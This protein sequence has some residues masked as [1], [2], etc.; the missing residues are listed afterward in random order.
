MSSGVFEH[1][2]VIMKDKAPFFS[3]IVPTY[4]RPR[5][6]DSCLNALTRLDYPRDRFEVIVIDDASEIRLDPIVSPYRKKIDVALITQP[7]SGP[8]MARNR[9]AARAK[10]Q[11]LAFTDDDCEPSPDWIKALSAR[12]GGM[13]EQI[14]GGRTLN[15]LAGNAY[16][17]VTQ[18]VTDYVIHHSSF[19]LSQKRFF[20]SNNLAIP[21]DCFHRV[22]GFNTDFPFGAGEDRELS[23]RLIDHQLPLVYAPEVI[24]YHSHRFTLSTFL[25][26]HFDYGRG[27]FQFHQICARRRNQRIM[28]ESKRFYLNLL[29][30]PLSKGRGIRT[31]LFGALVAL[32]Q[33]ANAAGY[34][35][36]RLL[37][38]GR[39]NF[40]S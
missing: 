23:Q 36:E 1:T 14:V 22:G 12:F 24:V 4:N 9:G 33:A 8:A 15:W 6:L 13:S 30:L 16:A 3:V 26:R 38:T 35:W 2:S 21:A 20:P 32:S 28:L 10:G 11:Y 40:C 17:T 31:M 5:Q 37:G 39:K 34:S 19:D 29:L 25:R 27:S 18:M 7:H